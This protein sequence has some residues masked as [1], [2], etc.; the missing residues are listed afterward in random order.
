MSGQRFNS[1][2]LNQAWWAISSESPI[3]HPE[4][5]KYF[6]NDDHRSMLLERF[7][8]LDQ[9]DNPFEEEFSE[10]CTLPL[11]KYFEKLILLALHIDPTYE[12][13]GSNIQIQRRNVT[14]GEIDLLVRHT[15][16]PEIEHWEIALKYYLRRD[17]NGMK[18]LVGPNGNDLLS[19]KLQRMTEHQLP[20]GQHPEIL[21]LCG[22]RPVSKV[23]FK[24]L[25]FAELG[26]ELSFDQKNEK[27]ESGWWIRES[28][29]AKLKQL[30]VDGWEILDKRHWI[31]KLITSNPPSMD[32][33]DLITKFENRDGLDHR[34]VCVVGMSKTD[35][36]WIETTRG[37]VVKD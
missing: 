1:S 24:G 5:V 9:S 8:A 35:T 25:F 16:S 32:L 18:T 23:F 30:N 27:A 22:S 12:V 36:G 3:I 20:L 11:G 26:S 33:A 34:S 17:L 4:A 28:E 10:Y 7:S 13:I 14:I 21:D 6:R 37:F 31:G 2:I 29:I 15:S 19:N